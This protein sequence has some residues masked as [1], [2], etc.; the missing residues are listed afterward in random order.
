[1]KKMT[2]SQ[3]GGACDM[4]FLAETFEEIAA[5]SQAHGTEMFRKEDG[6]HLEAMEK[7]KSLM[8]DPE[9][10]NHWF[11]KKRQEFDSLPEL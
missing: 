7:M 10:M 6:P 4:E 11:E 3:L 9:A 5:K 8:A 1:M 2:C